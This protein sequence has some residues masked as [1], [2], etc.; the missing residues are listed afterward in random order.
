MLEGDNS[1]AAYVNFNRLRSHDNYVV[2]T[3][4]K[5]DSEVSVYIGVFRTPARDSLS[6]GLCASRRPQSTF[7]QERRD[8]NCTWKAS[9]M[10]LYKKKKGR[11]PYP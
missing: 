10:Y 3:H 8:F 7:H 11:F 5:A 9:F 1:G 2:H 6:E 4:F